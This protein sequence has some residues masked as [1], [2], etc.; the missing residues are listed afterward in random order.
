M[1]KHYRKETQDSFDPQQTFKPEQEGKPL[2]ITR[3]LEDLG[4][5]EL[6][7]QHLKTLKQER[8]LS[9]ETINQYITPVNQEIIEQVKEEFTSS[10]LVQSGWFKYTCKVCEQEY[11]PNFERFDTFSKHLQEEHGRDNPDKYKDHL[12]SLVPK[13][14]FL[15]KYPDLETGDLVYGNIRD[16]DPRED[17]NKYCQ[18]HQEHVEARKS[19]QSGIFPAMEEIGGE[20]LIIT[21]GEFKSLALKEQGWDSIAIAGVNLSQGNLDRLSRIASQYDQVVYVVDD[22]M[23]GLLSVPSMNSEMNYRN[24]KISVQVSKDQDIDDKHSEGEEFDLDPVEPVELLKQHVN[25]LNEKEHLISK[26]A[27]KPSDLLEVFYH[28]VQGLKRSKQESKVKQAVEHINKETS[29]EYGKN[30]CK[31]ELTDWREQFV[32]NKRQ[33]QQNQEDSTTEVSEF[34]STIQIDNKE[35]ALNPVEYVNI[36]EHV[37]TETEIL[38]NDR[39]VV[40]PDKKFKIYTVSF[41]KG[42]EEREYR[43]LVSPDKKL[44]LGDNYLPLKMADLDKEPYNEWVQNQYRKASGD[45]E[46]TFE[47]FKE[48]RFEGQTFEIAGHLNKESIK[49]IKELDN[50]TI[51]EQILEKYLNNGFDYDSDLTELNHP[52]II[53]HDKDKVDPEDIMPHNP[54]SA[55]ITGTKVGKSFDSGRVGVVRTKV[56]SSGLLGYATADDVRTGTLDG[57]VKPFFADE[58]RHGS[59]ENVG[60]NLLTILEKGE[61]PMSKGQKD[62]RPCFYGSFTYMSNPQSQQDNKNQVDYFLDFIQKVGNNARATGS[63]LGILLLD[64]GEMDKATGTPLRKEQKNKLE[65]VVEWLKKE[66]SGSYSD[67]ELQLQEWLNQEYPDQYVD[68]VNDWKDDLHSQKAGEFLEGHLESYRHAR[69]QALRMAV[70]QNVSDVINQEYDVD[71]IRELADDKFQEVMNINLRG[72]SNLASELGDEEKVIGRKGAL[73]E[74][75]DNLYIKLFVKTAVLKYRQKPESLKSIEPV[76][77][78][79]DI[80]HKLREELDT[81]ED[82]DW[83]WK[84]SR[85]KGTIRDNITRINGKLNDQYGLSVTE[86]H[87]TLFIKGSDF[88]I[89]RDYTKLPEESES[90]PEISSGEESEES[91]VGESKDNTTHPSSDDSDS[92]ENNSDGKVGGGSK[93]ENPT[94]QTSRTSRH[95]EK[96]QENQGKSSDSSESS[97]SDDVFFSEGPKIGED[98]EEET[99]VKLLKFFQ[100]HGDM[101]KGKVMQEIDT[102]IDDVGEKLKDLKNLE[103]LKYDKH[104]HQYM[105]TDKG[106]GMVEN[107]GLEQVIE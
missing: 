76:D 92:E 36:K 23:G 35:I 44:N 27:N 84:W 77:S 105:I 49:K 89:F 80:F 58:I 5:Q 3:K 72:I 62:M 100:E 79:Q 88:S 63:R 87:D 15:I 40:R 22:D 71:E 53:R 74:A 1:N 90:I 59:E 4:K 12:F 38:Q 101:K 34:Q 29:E 56:S 60:D 83:Y 33:R 104:T 10:S 28:T 64:M 97:D 93:T 106:V 52:K 61:A 7:D 42:Q 19:F 41:D 69:G 2:E 86:D 39:D 70:Y 43:L 25:R 47:Q 9:E 85:V 31:S 55:Y 65:T 96:S 68:R 20:T 78:L 67:I 81:V 45:Y 95:S 21:E 99:A 26:Y 54:H 13:E 18:P 48:E 6:T 75:E 82:G 57:M 32:R 91:E 24:Q 98:I 103:L 8:G 16:R 66:M 30:T 107:Q 51:K 37:K 73:L 50:Q 102:G 46:G 94:S 17:G 11:G 14:G